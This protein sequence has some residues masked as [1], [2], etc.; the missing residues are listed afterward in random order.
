MRSG[1][2]TRALEAVRDHLA[3]KLETAEGGETPAI[4]RAL[5]GVLRELDALPGAGARSS[6]DDIADSVRDDLA[7]RLAHRVTAAADL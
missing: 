4:A 3:L 7:D 2:R 5:M 1:S 6:I